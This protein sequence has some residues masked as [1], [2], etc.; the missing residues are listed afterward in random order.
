MSTTYNFTPGKVERIQTRDNNGYGTLRI[1]KLKV[2]VFQEQ[3]FLRVSTK[4]SL[5]TNGEVFQTRDSSMMLEPKDSKT[6]LPALLL[7]SFKTKLLTAQ[8]CLQMNQ[9]QQLAK[10]GKLNIK[11]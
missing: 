2:L 5:H 11:T 10:N 3:L 6:D 8:T 1:K 4:I 9:T 7:T